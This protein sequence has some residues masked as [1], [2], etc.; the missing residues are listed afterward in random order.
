MSTVTL[1]Y[2]AELREQIGCSQGTF[3]LDDAQTVESLIERLIASEGASF[4]V[5]QQ[6][7]VQVAINSKLG[8]KAS[9]IKPGNEVAFFP[10]VTGG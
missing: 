7:K 1:L 10:P 9:M 5:L 8:D 6:D 2:F 4:K 3:A